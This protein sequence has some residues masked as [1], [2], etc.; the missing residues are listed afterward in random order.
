MPP[1]GSPEEHDGFRSSTIREARTTPGGARPQVIR[2]VLSDEPIAQRGLSEPEVIRI[3][4]H[5]AAVD[6]EKASPKC[7]AGQNSGEPSAMGTEVAAH[8][9][10]AVDGTCRGPV[11]AASR[12]QP[13]P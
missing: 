13:I 8:C 9:R 2:L 12:W 6:K 11:R 10:M 7:M 1:I 5:M 3:I 4:F